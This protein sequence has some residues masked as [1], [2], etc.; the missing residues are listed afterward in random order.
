M[1]E[2]QS[3]W[4][5]SH[6]SP[7]KTKPPDVYLLKTRHWVWKEPT[8]QEIPRASHTHK[9]SKNKKGGRH[10]SDDLEIW[11]SLKYTIPFITS[12]ITSK[13]LK[14]ACFTRQGRKGLERYFVSH[15]KKYITLC[16]T[17]LY[18]ERETK[19]LIFFEWVLF[20]RTYTGQPFSP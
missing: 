18:L 12:K 9:V 5:D 8:K 14:I 6:T 20:L 15:R 4:Y 19:I 11:P 10:M 1:K 2:G 16:K 17:L 3:D 13:H 7:S